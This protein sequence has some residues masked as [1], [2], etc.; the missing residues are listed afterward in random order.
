[1]ICNICGSS[2]LD[3][4]ELEDKYYYCNNCEAIF[5]DPEAIV[6]PETE[7]QRYDDHDN[8]HQNDGYVKM[9]KDF[10][11][12]FLKLKLDL[13]QI[14]SVLDFGCGP[15]PVLADLLTVRGLE[16]DCYD[17]YFFPAKKF[18]DKKYDLITATEVFEHFSDPIAEIKLLK[19]HLKEDSYLAI[20]TN[21]HPGPEKFADWWY[22]WD[23][24]HIVFYNQK[25]FRE[26]ASNYGLEI[27][28]TDHKQYILL[29]S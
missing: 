23:P 15:G 13:E 7:K 10:I 12:S 8:N 22:K 19:A 16:V 3:L 6:D 27:V 28:Y 9:F 4:L 26:I 2:N 11:N 18:K 24:T 14:E 17:P 25:T 1:M 20:M 21:F 5:I 29:K